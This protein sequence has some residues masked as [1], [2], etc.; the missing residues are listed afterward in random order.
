MSF[1]DTGLSEDVLKAVADSGYD[2]PTPIQEKAIPT[3]LMGRDILG[4]A[5]TGTGKTASFTLPMIDILA[6]GR[7]KM[8][9]PRSLILEPTRELATQVAENFDKY[10]KYSKLNKALLI[11]GTDMKAQIK[12]LDSG[13]DVLIA[14]PGRLLDMFERGHLIMRDVKILVID[15]ADRMLDMGFIP[16]IEKIVAMLPPLRQ[17][18]FFSATMAPEI[19]RLADKFLQNPKEISVS[20]PAST[21]A[22][23]TQGLAIVR[24]G[25]EHRGLDG[26]KKLKRDVL[27][28]MI[29][30]EAVSDAIVFCNRKM[31]VASVYKSLSKRGYKVGQLHGDM[32][33][34]ARTEMLA[35]F[36]NKDFNILVC[37]DVAARGLD[38]PN[39]SHVFNFD[40]PINA[41]DYVHRIGRTGRAGKEGHAYSIALPED[42]KYV[43]AI[44]KLIGKEIPRLEMDGFA[45]A[46]LSE[47]DD[48]GGRG[49]R[50]GRS[51]GR[52]GERGGRSRDRGSRDRKPAPVQTTPVQTT[53]VQTAPESTPAVAD[54]QPAEAKTS[55]APAPQPEATSKRKERGAR[56]G[57]RGRGRDGQNRARQDRGRERT[58]VREIHNEICDGHMP[59][60]LMRAPDAP[61]SKGEKPT[62]KDEK[63]AAPKKAAPKKRA[64]RKKAAPK[65]D[66][67]AQTETSNSSED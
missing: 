23:V 44:E 51:G 52:G 9:M 54:E 40:I 42:G 33:Q 17:T 12:I 64:P 60:F 5:Q 26:K 36:K 59:A 49:G 61:A 66:T 14:T 56:D 45:K 30:H 3:V 38:I 27:R 67:P 4:C 11:G 65:A 10:G 35:G 2:T 24:P 16:D 58:A 21:A 7:A 31:D 15:E 39:L 25:G 13:A 41:E 57:G 1:A 19:K 50:G 6:H 63:K 18:L 28:E 34:P 22:T 37:S 55:S 8:R 46:E 29:D 48:R 32:S 43:S 53:P 47:G 62:S 20:A